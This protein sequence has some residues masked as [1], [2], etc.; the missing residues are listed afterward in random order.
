M[1]YHQAHSFGSLKCEI[2]DF[3]L[4]HLIKIR[5]IKKFKYG[6]SKSSFTINQSNQKLE[7]TEAT[8]GG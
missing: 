7:K 4:P 6:Y 5:L 8:N 1:K 2:V 3:E